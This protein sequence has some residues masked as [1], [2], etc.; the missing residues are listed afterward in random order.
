MQVIVFSNRV[1][2]KSILLVIPTCMLQSSSITL[3]VSQ[4][5]ALIRGSGPILRSPRNLER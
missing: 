1:A 4:S 2:C 5:L 3:N